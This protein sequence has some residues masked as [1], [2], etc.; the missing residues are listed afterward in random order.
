[1]FSRFFIDRPIFASVLS[2]IIVLIGLLS[3]TWLPLAQ[4]PRIAPP[5]V[6]VTCNYPG[7]DAQVVATAVAAPIEEFVNGVEG[8]M[9]MSSQCT[10]DGTYNLTVT[11]NPSVQLNMAQVLVQNRINLA[12]PRLPA[13]IKQTGVSTRKRSP[14][15]LLVVC[16]YSPGGRHDQLFLSNF[17]LT[18]VRDVLLRLE[19]V[20][21]CNLFGQRDYSMR[22]WVNPDQLAHRNMTVSD[23]VKSLREQNLHIATGQIGQ[24]PIVKGQQIQLTLDVT[25][26]LKDIEQFENVVVKST[27]DGRMVRIKDI[28]RVEL[29]A[30]NIDISQML[31]GK[32]CCGL[33]FFQ[34]P[35]ANA[36]ETAERCLAKMNELKKTFPPNVDFEIS[37]DTTPYTRESIFEVFKTLRDAIILVA[38]VV[39]VFLQNWHRRSFP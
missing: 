13:V 19:G 32:P 2:I 28:G 7:A 29:G 1:M 20:G 33:A 27:P 4:F 26:R 23:V 6:S 21:D 24:P 30:K 18:K 5:I 38:L 9:Y 16:V 39:L 14:D 15:I 3:L 31:D 12:L 22:I 34:L 10:N 8:M 35:E 17:A 36:L 37:F 25:G 11:F